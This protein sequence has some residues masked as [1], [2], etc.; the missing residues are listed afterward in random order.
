MTLSSSDQTLFLMVKSQLEQF[1]QMLGRHDEVLMRLPQDISR[2]FKEHRETCEA[3]NHFHEVRNQI[4]ET[5]G[6]VNVQEER[7][8]A[9]QERLAKN[10]RYPR[11]KQPWWS[12]SALKIVLAAI[13]IM[14]GLGAWGFTCSMSQAD[15]KKATEIAN[16]I[17][18]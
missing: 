5:T 1:G 3:N 10:S 7:I 12:P 13:G 14:G 4:L 15:S 6:V 9:A 17:E 18:K 2:A 8:R 16:K 11:E